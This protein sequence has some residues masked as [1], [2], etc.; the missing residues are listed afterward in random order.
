[1]AQAPKPS[2]API[3]RKTN[4]LWV[5]VSVVAAGI[6]FLPIFGG[7]V[8][9]F[10]SHA[11]D[12]IK[13]NGEANDEIKLRANYYRNIV[14]ARL[15]KPANKVDVGDFLLVARSDPNFYKGALADIDKKRD[16]ANRTSAMINGAVAAVGLM[17]LPVNVA[18]IGKGLELAANAGDAGKM[19]KA[20]A[21]VVSAAKHVVPVVGAGIAGSA[22]ASFFENDHINAQDVV[23]RIHSC[24][25]DAESRG[26][27]A[28]GAVTPQLV[29]LLR[30]ARD[31]KL[32]DEIKKAKGKPYHQLSADDQ[33]SVMKAYPALADAVTS[34][35]Y[36]VSNQMITPQELAA[37]EPNLNGSSAKYT[38]GAQN[39]S[40]VDAL[41]AQRAK[42]SG[43]ETNLN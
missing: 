34:E 36:A 6:C 18:G 1:M 16:D 22:A 2:I 33:L 13:N 29:F 39:A 11:A 41:K 40:F 8:G 9:G 5:G 43:P 42:A 12:R 26:V 23:E 10:I 30:V 17:P 28:K 37:K 31:E 25:L 3:Q 19:V 4:Y 24:L 15:N 32:A 14:A 27:S 7:A 35:A 20:G 38:I 21:M